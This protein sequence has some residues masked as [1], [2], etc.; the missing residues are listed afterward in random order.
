MSHLRHSPIAAEYA[1]DDLEA[2][3]VRGA[4]PR[5][6]DFD[7]PFPRARWHGL[8]GPGPRSAD[9]ASR[10]ADVRPAKVRSADVAVDQLLA[11]PL[12][13]TRFFRGAPGAEPVPVPIG[14]RARGA[15]GSSSLGVDSGGRSGGQDADGI[16]VAS[17]WRWSLEWRIG[18]VE[19]SEVHALLPHQRINKFPRATTLT[20]K[21]NLWM[22]VNHLRKAFGEEHFGFMPTTFC[23]PKEMAAF[24]AYMRSRLTAPGGEKDLWICKPTAAYCGRGITLHRSSNG[25]PEIARHAA[26]RARARHTRRC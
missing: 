13:R 7:A 11:R 25:L 8:A 1:R 6:R 14:I 3:D 17:E 18:R 5:C 9:L 24:D 12:R 26:A 19:A 15:L 10:Q 4:A 16:A 2:R 20:L 22:R 21:S 23:L